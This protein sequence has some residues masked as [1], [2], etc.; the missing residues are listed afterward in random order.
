MSRSTVTGRPAR[1]PSAWRSS[2]AGA[3]GTAG[4]TG[5]SRRCARAFPGAVSGCA[6][7]DV[8]LLHGISVPDPRSRLR[9]VLRPGCTGAAVQQPRRG[10][11]RPRWVGFPCRGDRAARRHGSRR[12]DGP[13][14]S[15]RLSPVRRARRMRLS[16]RRSSTSWPPSP[17]R[18]W[19]PESLRASFTTRS[20]RT[21]SASRRAQWADGARPPSRYAHDVPASPRQRD[22]HRSSPASPMQ[23]SPTSRA[24][25]CL[26]FRGTR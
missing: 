24:I 4:R 13:R 20:S 8:F 9:G 16:R 1:P 21:R 23:S 19:R 3:T 25:A 5:S 6:I 11:R 2:R 17:A 14:G 26:P 18:R 10:P 7:V 15:G 22:R 12:T